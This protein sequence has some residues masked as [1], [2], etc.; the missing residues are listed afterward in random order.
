MTCPEYP[1][2]GDDERAR[3]SRAG[4]R[5]RER[6][7]GSGSSCRRRLRSP[8]RAGSTS[9]RK[10]SRPRRRGS[11]RA[12]AASEAPPPRPRARSS[13]ADRRRWTRTRPADHEQA[14]EHERQHRPRDQD[15]PDHQVAEV[16]LEVDDRKRQ[17][18]EHAE[19]EERARKPPIGMTVAGRRE[20]Q[21][22]TT[23]DHGKGAAVRLE[24][25]GDAGEQARREEGGAAPGLQMA[26]HRRLRREPRGKRVPGGIGH[27][28]R[29]EHAG[30]D[31]QEA[32]VA[33]R[34]RARERGPAHG[35]ASTNISVMVSVFTIAQEHAHRD[36]A[37][38]EQPEERGVHVEDARRVPGLEVDVGLLAVERPE[39]PGRGSDPRPRTRD[40]T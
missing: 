29:G 6:C 26:I 37:V 17:D 23:G 35:R 21:R 40:H 27:V 4:T 18:R 36:R 20:R 2:T 16:Q 15:E 5:S 3:S 14:P 33:E 1:E 34:R 31:R 38:A 9:R 12:T 30:K 28:E 22:E 39:W 25:E 8:I 13:P 24:R 32:R 19:H 11:T 10:R 7:A